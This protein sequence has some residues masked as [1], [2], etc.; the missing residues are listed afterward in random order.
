M[1]QFRLYPEHKRNF[2]V[3]RVLRDLA[4]LDH[5]PLIPAPALAL[6]PLLTKEGARGRSLVLRDKPPGVPL[7]QWR[8]LP[9]QHCNQFFHSFKGRRG[10]LSGGKVT[11]H[12]CNPNY[13]MNPGE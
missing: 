9:G 12:S 3:D 6:V 5:D 8:T 1:P 2:H 10:R 13:I 11:P 4:L 7:N